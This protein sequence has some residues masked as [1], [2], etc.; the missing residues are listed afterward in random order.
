[1]QKRKKDIANN[2]NSEGIINALPALVA[3]VTPDHRY[4]F[5]NEAYF[6]VF[7]RNR[8][9]I[10]GHHISE[11]LGDETYSRIRPCL[12]R[13]LKGE[14]ITHVEISLVN[15]F[16]ER[17]YYRGTYVPDRKGGEVVGIVVLQTDVTDLKGIERR[18]EERD[19][20]LRLSLESAD[21]GIGEFSVKE[22]T[23][24][25]DENARRIFSFTEKQET[26]SFKEFI[27]RVYVEDADRLKR[28]V[29]A[30]RRDPR[31][32]FD[33]DY[34]VYDREKKG[35]KW[36]HSRCRLIRD[37][38]NE[39]IRAVFVVADATKQKLME[40]KIRE[41]EGKT[42][43]LLEYLPEF[44]WTAAPDGTLTYANR[45]YAEYSGLEV[46]NPET[47]GW[48]SLVH[49]DDLERTRKLWER[50]LK[51]GEGFEFEVRLRRKDG[52]Y[53]WF[54]SRGV[55]V[56]DENGN[57]IEWFGTTTDIHDRKVAEE[58]QARIQ[59]K[60]IR[61]QA[62]ANELM[63][64]D[65]VEDIARVIIE[66]G[67]QAVDASAGCVVLMT[68]DDKRDIQVVYDKL[69]DKVRLDTDANHFRGI[70][71]DACSSKSP[72]YIYSREEVKQRYPELNQIPG[73]DKLQSLAVLPL[74]SHNKV[75]GAI[76]LAFESTEVFSPERKS[77]F[78]I[79]AE[80]AALA[81]ERARLFEAEK[82]ARA[83]AEIASQAR[84]QF[85]AN[86][87]HEIR[88]PMNAILGFTD[89][90]GDKG[91]TEEER[92]EYR[93]RIRANGDQLLHLIDDI[94]D[95]SKVEADR[96]EFEK[97]PF[98]AIDLIR[99]VHD[100]LSVMIQGKN[101]KTRLV[102]SDNVPQ[103]I[104]SDPVRLRQ[105][106]TNL[107][108]NAAKFT[109]KGFIETRVSFLPESKYSRSSLVIDVE[110]T[111]IGIPDEFRK[112]LFAPFSQGD[113][114]VTRRFGGTGLGLALSQKFAEA[115]GGSLS[116]LHSSPGQG[117][118]FRLILPV[119]SRTIKEKKGRDGKVRSVESDISETDLTG[120]RI[121]LAE[122]SPDNEALI[123]AYLKQTGAEIQVARDGAEALEKALESDF[124]LILMDIQMPR[125]DGLEATRRL[126][127]QN[128]KRPIVALSAHALAEEVQR[129]LAAGCQAHLT[130][131]VTRK[132]LIR[133]IKEALNM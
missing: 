32:S 102:I 100:S 66:E 28:I 121:L 59:R 12:D 130:K 34:R 123:R 89:L 67:M 95:L 53:R 107:L 38:R 4:R 5:I 87:S 47:G 11:I 76:S 120:T 65:S 81:I 1:V 46:T 44:V 114:S 122:D 23:I 13:A 61:L 92:E 58:R 36:I 49:Q 80:Q 60:V 29:K 20:R 56:R 79:L 96:L 99:D 106:L 105:I 9:N 14:I 115:L 25:L 110:D 40:R 62:I 64:S 73:T 57:L 24:T 39:V 129:S 43:L 104:M 74:L 82:A 119:E 37:E 83:S 85:L 45:R 112:N 6:R 124:D 17:R 2:W 97:V 128:F 91:L 51:Q 63:Q 77:Y 78:V 75:L 8:E 72:I 109:T 108:G 35:P 15:R 19:V 132:A 22:Y 16:G 127:Q 133:G 86:M 10:V 55:P 42:R 118:V 125:M 50:V 93:K 31:Q 27:T 7:G 84:S 103:T 26:L 70:A 101:I 88:T 33:I 41:S 116:L 94:L 71:L 52:A 21:M 98:S 30:I 117:S 113:S 54:L 90:L 131:P 69:Q 126:R 111:G 48:L 3:Y 68:D 18:L